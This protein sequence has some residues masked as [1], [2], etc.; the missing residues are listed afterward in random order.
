MR[1]LTSIIAEPGLSIILERPPLSPPPTS[2]P[3]IDA[4]WS[5]RRRS[6]AA[7]RRGRRVEVDPIDELPS[8]RL[9]GGGAPRSPMSALES[10][11]LGD[12]LG[13]ARG[14]RMLG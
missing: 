3:M 14:L 4:W 12:A 1:T 5:P 13:K 8:L 11:A 10:C 9:L 6:G 2:L 7:Y